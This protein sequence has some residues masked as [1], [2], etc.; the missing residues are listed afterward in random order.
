MV[1]CVHWSG[2]EF[3]SSLRQDISTSVSLDPC[4][5]GSLRKN[6]I[7]WPESSESTTRARI[8]TEKVV[9]LELSRGLPI[10]KHKMDW[11]SETIKIAEKIGLFYGL[12]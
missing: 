4:M 12:E 11:E 5:T 7:E 2:G 6:L 10:I 1:F 3:T 9:D 8:K